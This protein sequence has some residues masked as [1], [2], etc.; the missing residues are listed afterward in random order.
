MWNK[1]MIFVL[2]GATAFGLIAA[3]SVSRYLAG[4][5]GSQRLN[6]VVVAK[7]E[8]PHGA[9]I[10]A[11]QLTTVQLPTN[12]TPA[13]TFDKF[14]GVVGRIAITRI[15][16]QEPIV[17][18]RLAPEGSAAG[19]SALIPEG[20]RAMT[21]KV[22][23][24]AGIAGFLMPGTLVDVLAVITP[25]EQGLGQNPISKIVLQNIKV[26]ASGTNLDE[27]KNGREAETVKTV[28]LQV[29]PEQAEKLVLS[30]AE[31]R[32]RLALRNST[33]Q[34]DEQTPG[35]NKRTL[36]TGESALPV[37]E[38]AATKPEQAVKVQTVRRSPKPVMASVIEKANVTPAP[39]Q[40]TPAPR[41]MVE[42]FEGGKKRVVDFPK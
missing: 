23:D 21:V 7:I 20:Y 4:A 12:A 27:P 11:E 14:E 33:D 6:T 35:A 5:Q 29:T 1:T 22:D 15:L 3:V 39:P 24:E 9:K 8:I 32:L 16:Q 25:A 37:P 38:P 42:M 19:L 26:L 28:T 31:G 13:G 40:P 41:V 10:T 18:T 30:S 34:G 2:A 36:L 17:A